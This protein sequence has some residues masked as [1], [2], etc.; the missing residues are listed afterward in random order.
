MEQTGAKEDEQ[1]N[2]RLGAAERLYYSQMCDQLF[3]RYT[4]IKEVVVVVVVLVVVLVLVTFAKE[5]M[6]Y[7][8]IYLSLCQQDYTK[9]LPSWI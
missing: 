8:F 6:R 9:K 1:M 7:L 5:I 4:N 3:E 2:G